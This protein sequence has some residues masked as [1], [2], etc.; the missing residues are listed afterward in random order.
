MDLV[1]T[2]LL[3]MMMLVGTATG[4]SPNV[5]PMP[6][7]ALPTPTPYVTQ[8]PTAV[9]TARP[10]AAPRATRY[11]T[12][13]VGDKGNAVRALQNRLQELGYL[14]TSPDGSYGAQTKTA[15]E[16]FQRANGLKVDGIAGRNTQQ[17]LFESPDVIYANAATAIPTMPPVTA[18]PVAP[19]RV[20]IQYLDA[21]TNRLLAQDIAQCYGD[22]YLYADATKVPASYRL[23]SN[24]YVF[25]SVRNSQAS[26]STVTFR[27]QAG[28]TAAPAT[29]V[30]VPVY[31]LD[32]NNLIVA[33]ETRTLY[34]TGAVT[35]DTSLIP[36]GYSLSGSSVVYVTIQSGAASPNPIIFR[37]NRYVVT[38][39]PTPVTS[40]VV[41]VNY[42]DNTTGRVFA[43]QNVSLLRTGN[44]FPQRSLVPE[45]YTLLSA[46]YVTVTVSNG[47]ANPSRV[48]FRYQPY[49][50]TATPIVSVA[51]PVNYVEAAGNRVIYRTTV[52][53]TASQRVYADLSLV[54]GYTLASASSVY[55]TVRNGQASPASVTF[56]LNRI[57]TPTPMPVY[58]VSVPVRYLYGSRLI[59]SQT[60][61]IQNGTSTYVYADA[62]AYG[63]NYVIS[64]A[65]YARV[66][67]SQNGVASP[68]TVTFYVVPRST[69]TP[70]PIPNFNVAVPVRYLYGSRLVASQTV[71]IRNGTTTNVYADASVYGANYVISGANYQRVTVSQTGVAS[72]ST[73]TFNVVPRSTP[74]PTPIPSF[75]VSIPVRY[76]YGTRL[77][78]TQSVSIR[79]GTTT[80]VYADA[81]VYGANYV[82]SGANYQRVTVSQTGVASP[83][84]VTF[85][86]VPRVTPTPTAVPVTEVPVKV[87]YMD[88]TR[89]VASYQEM[90]TTGTTTTI[91]ADSSVYQGRYILQG[92]NWVNVTVN[93]L[94]QASPS[95][96]VFNL[97]PVQTPTPT[98][99]PS[100]DVSVPVRYMCDNQLISGYQEVCPSN[101]TTIVY[102]DPS[103]YE[104]RYNLISDNRVNVI[105]DAN[106]N[107]RPSTVIFYLTP[108]VTPSPV[109]DPPSFEVPVQVEYR[110]GSQLVWSTTVMLMSG[111]TSTVQADPS[112][113]AS[114]YVLD[115]SDSIPVS[116]SADGFANPNPVTFYLYP[117]TPVTPDPGPTAAPA[118][119][120]AIITGDPNQELPKFIKG[121][122]FQSNYDIYQGP[123]RNYY[124]ANNGKASYGARGAAR[125]YGTDGEWLLIGYE[126]GGGDYRIGYI[127][128]YKLPD[129][130]NAASIP[131]LSYAML[132]TNLIKDADVTDDPVINA[133][134]FDKL[135][136]GTEVTFLAWSDD[137][138]IWALV[139]YTSSKGTVR[140][141]VR[142]VCLGELN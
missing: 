137:R 36:A 134:R 67:V 3:Y 53:M 102:A 90:C 41:P 132:K 128:N 125:V 83:S 74:T 69:P 93:Q 61:S 57:A 50:P 95:M 118:P 42:I 106:G 64:G 140:A 75:N 89:L 2:V 15:V 139:E 114:Q 101:T 78:A 26:P 112:V 133:K 122:K 71:S 33:R 72:P 124:R 31:Y 23:V 20:V 28:A 62:S 37:L 51:V 4:V 115:G 99:I 136:A 35:A 8:A 92:D 30:S 25:V 5:T 85:Y 17:V 6:A 81:S 46:S 43:T 22:T 87:N 141:F 27:Y 105:V 86:V 135:S 38:A 7:N 70:T 24:S 12:L 104:G 52:P 10:T 103:V 39:T 76:L 91:Y 32:A 55:V 96:V 120:P 18:T 68:S 108:V 79:N 54:P 73:V 9:P 119:G 11:T 121:V 56:S 40:V 130:V 44:V 63:A 109:T 84:T 45:G 138:H 80:N 16:N 111:R 13:Y 107:A 88:G 66:T 49:Q 48:E 58:Q 97:V 59:A 19:A 65:N 131:T 82:I 142:D 117:A 127:H 14:R 21:G 47:R 94:G 110:N 60:V 29:G 100:Y 1:K 34:Q 98:P 129:N 113:Y 126:T 116:V 123:G 77:V